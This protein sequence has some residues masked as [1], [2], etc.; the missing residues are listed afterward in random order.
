MS[1]QSP[2]SILNL[3]KWGTILLL[4]VVIGCVFINVRA[5]QVAKERELVNLADERRELE[6]ALNRELSHFKSQ[7][8]PLGLEP[9]LK[10]FRSELVKV[11]VDRTE[12]LNRLLTASYQRR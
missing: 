5:Q 8:T 7:L 12:S 6:L 11:G 3:L 9:R 4:F 10:A 2:L 1:E